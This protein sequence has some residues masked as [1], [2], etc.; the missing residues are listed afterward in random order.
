[1]IAMFVTTASPIKSFVL[2][3]PQTHLSK[4]SS[5]NKTIYGQKFIASQHTT[6]YDSPFVLTTRSYVDR[7]LKN[8]SQQRFVVDYA[9][10]EPVLGIFTPGT[11]TQGAFI[12]SQHL[13]RLQ[14]DGENVEVGNKI[15]VKNQGTQSYQNGIYTVVRKGAP[16]TET[17]VIQRAPGATMSEQFGYGMS[18]LVTKGNINSKKCWFMSTD[19][20]IVLDVTPLFFEEY[21]ITETIAG[22]GLVIEDNIISVQT[23]PNSGIQVSDD[24]V[25]LDNENSEVSV[26]FT[27]RGPIEKQIF[28]QAISIFGSNVSRHQPTT[29]FEILRATGTGLKV[30]IF[31]Q[32][33]NQSQMYI[34]LND[35]DIDFSLE[36][37]FSTIGNPLYVSGVKQTT[38]TIIVP[39]R[40]TKQYMRVGDSIYVF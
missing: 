38:P 20:T 35:S 9:T 37:Q 18:V 31:D 30:S 5:T 21:G 7:K 40:N 22:A 24:H 6:E 32:D 4:M 26:N 27:T 29:S 2:N 13:V 36:F 11:Q 1:M 15:L 28:K 17:Y 8:V 23:N 34:V 33:L 12:R 16:G 19:S 3:K 39:G 10:T 14:I 25:N